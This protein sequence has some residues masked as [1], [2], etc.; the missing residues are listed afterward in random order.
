MR[1]VRSRRLGGTGLQVSEISLGSW[2][3]IGKALD[4]EASRAL[5]RHAFDLGINFFDTAQSYPGAEEY[6]GSILEQYR[7]EEYVIASKC[8]FP[9][10]ENEHVT[11]ARGDPLIAGRQH[12]ARADPQDLVPTKAEAA[13]VSQ[14]PRS[15]AAQVSP[16]GLCRILNDHQV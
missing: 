7:R 14:R 8:Y 15:P 4:L 16:M 12:P 9:R 5:V 11:G 6:L 3:T 2:M 1:V 10:P 13:H